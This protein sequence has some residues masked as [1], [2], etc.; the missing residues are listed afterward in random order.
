MFIANLYLL[1]IKITYTTPIQ[2]AINRE[3][4]IQYNKSITDFPCPSNLFS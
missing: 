3:I 4:T 1:Y 2:C